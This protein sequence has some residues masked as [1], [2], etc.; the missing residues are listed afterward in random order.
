MSDSLFGFLMGICVAC[1]ILLSL[2][3][4]L[5]KENTKKL[6]ELKIK[7]LEKELL[8]K[9]DLINKIKKCVDEHWDNPYYIRHQLKEILKI[10]E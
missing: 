2:Y 10:K 9:D 7:Q 3:L 5:T 6:Y 1:V 8:Y 4:F